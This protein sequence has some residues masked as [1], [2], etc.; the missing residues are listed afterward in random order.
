MAAHLRDLLAKYNGNEDQALAGY[1]AGTGTVDSWVRQNIFARIIGSSSS[2]ETVNYVRKV[3]N[4]Q[5]VYRSMY[6]EQLNIKADVTSQLQARSDQDKEA[7]IRGFVWSQVF[8][9]LLPF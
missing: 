2:S 6:A 4:Y 3:K 8:R 9:N 1:N 5:N 7:Q